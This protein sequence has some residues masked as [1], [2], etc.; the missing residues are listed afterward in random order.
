MIRKK[1]TFAN[2]L[3]SLRKD[4]GITQDALARMIGT[5][6]VTICRY[7]IGTREPDIETLIRIADALGVTVDELVK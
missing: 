5:A 7:E 2:R 3:A 1:S 6:R 4:K